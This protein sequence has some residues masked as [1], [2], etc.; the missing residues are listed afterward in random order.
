MIAEHQSHKE[1]LTLIS[2]LQDNGADDFRK[3]KTDN[4]KNFVLHMNLLS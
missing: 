2:V 4:R 3:S 1:G